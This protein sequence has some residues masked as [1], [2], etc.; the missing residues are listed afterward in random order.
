VAQAE[1]RLRLPVPQ[2]TPCS[3]AFGAGRDHERTRRLVW[4][5]FVC[6]DVLD[7]PVWTDD[8]TREMSGGRNEAGIRSARN[9]LPGS[10]HSEGALATEE[11]RAEAGR[12]GSSG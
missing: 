10:C 3:W 8:A 5:E 11:S 12:Q 9:R 7:R 6:R 1:A 2:D 4:E